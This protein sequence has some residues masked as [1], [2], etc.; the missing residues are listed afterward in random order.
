MNGVIESK[1]AGE[2]FSTVSWPA[3]HKDA[4]PIVPAHV[5]LDA[6]FLHSL[7]A[8][9]YLTQKIHHIWGGR[10][11]LHGFE[12][13]AA[14][15]NRNLEGKD[16]HECAL[17][18]FINCKSEAESLHGRYTAFAED[19]LQLLANRAGIGHGVTG[20]VSA[21]LLRIT[22]SVWP[23]LRFSGDLEKTAWVKRTLRH[24]E[25][26]IAQTYDSLSLALG[27][28]GVGITQAKNVIY[29]TGSNRSE[30]EKSRIIRSIWET[31]TA[32]IAA[33]AALENVGIPI[34]P[35]ILKGHGVLAV[36]SM[37]PL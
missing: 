32:F 35:S 26:F 36:Y 23:T 25:P 22:Q 10:P 31:D 14:A 9:A 33:E 8:Q 28:V 4:I 6:R 13:S 17:Q 21:P 19:A 24:P 7:E 27:R 18:I 37:P 15:I 3:D 30:D 2:S 34:D 20:L 1:A 11:V 5:R 16:R 29:E 12:Q